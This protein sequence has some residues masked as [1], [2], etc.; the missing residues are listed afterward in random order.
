M[1]KQAI[2]LTAAILV[3]GLVIAGCG[4]GGSDEASGA[5]KHPSKEEFVKQANAICVE[6]NA[7]VVR[8]VTKFFR[9]EGANGN[10]S[11][12]EVTS[13]VLIPALQSEA[14]ELTA[15]GTPTGDKKQVE[16]IV[17]SIEKVADEGEADVTTITKVKNPY[18]EAEKLSNAYGLKSCPIR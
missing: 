18:A 13:A 5:G 2:A 17:T 10:A 4:G 15:L 7:K 9:T 3:A 14:D 12:E 1:L 6:T 16:A 11:S 8:G